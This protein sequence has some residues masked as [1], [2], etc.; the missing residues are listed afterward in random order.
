MRVTCRWGHV[1]HV[2]AE[3]DV[4]DCIGN[5]RLLGVPDEYLTTEHYWH[6]ADMDNPAIDAHTFQRWEWLLEAKPWDLVLMDSVGQLMGGMDNN[7]AAEYREWHRQMP[8][9]ARLKGLTVV[10]IDHISKTQE[11][12]G[13]IGHPEGTT[14]KKNQADV[15]I[16]LRQVGDG[17]EIGKV[18]ELEILIT[19]DRFGSLRKTGVNGYKGFK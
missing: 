18:G 15:T 9:K 8:N 5:L 17:L 16:Y 7:S 4:F 2:D 1:L 11:L 10:M 14:N 6:I 3:M 13:N 12:A 19:K